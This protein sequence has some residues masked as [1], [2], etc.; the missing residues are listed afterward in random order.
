MPTVPRPWRRLDAASLAQK[1]ATLILFVLLT[2]AALLFTWHVL[3]AV[4]YRYPLDYGEGPLLDQAA[5]LAAGTNIYRADLTAPPYTISNYP[6]LYPLALALPTGLFGPSLAAGRAISGLC[7]VLTA[8]LLGLIV[9]GL[10]RDRCAAAVAGLT[11]LA[12]PY[13]LGWSKLAR[14]D[15]LA[16]ALSIGGLYLLVRWPGRWR[17]TILGGLLLVAAIYARQS[18]ALAAPLAAVGWLWAHDRRHAAGLAALVG[19]LSL[20]LFFGLNA[21]TGG[22]FAYNIITANVNDFVLA[23]LARWWRDLRGAAPVLLL[24]AGPFLVA[25]RRSVAW[26]LLAPYLIGASLSALTIG[27]V[28]SNMNYLLELCAA[29]SLMAGACVA[30]GR[31][32]PWLRATLLILL[33]LQVGLLMRASWRDPIAGLQWRMAQPRVALAELEQIIAAADGP[34][35]ADEYM[36]LLALQAKPL[37]IQPFEVTQL[38]KAGLWDQAP[39][40]SNI[41]ARAFPAIFIQHFRGYPVYQ[42][43]WTPEMLAAIMAHYEPTAFLAETIVYWPRAAG[44]AATTACPGGLW[45]LPTRSEMGLWQ[46]DRRLLFMGAGYEGDVPVYAVADG[47][48]LRPAGWYDAVAIQHDDPL[49]PGQKVWTYYGGMARGQGR[50]SLVAPRFTPGSTAVPVK[51]G[52]LLGYQGQYS[53]QFGTPF[54]VHLHFAVV[55]AA[56]DGTLPSEAVTA[57]LGWPPAPAAGE[58]E[59]LLAAA[60]YLG[61][62]EDLSPDRGTWRPL[63]CATGR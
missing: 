57:W 34:I 19:G 38:A 43:R 39:L 51:Q 63:R 50:G 30:W 11:L 25:G 24:L 16:L 21:L 35:L 32:C 41:R 45:R 47:L 59:E 33:A 55:P 54:W 27:K 1:S 12:F 58:G 17:G 13:V 26:P 56:A 29:L 5:R 18:Y 10:T 46:A 52:Q 49:R 37:Y 2:V 31:R 60:G 3:Q 42:E 36:G 48:L 15:L 61:I 44:D 7:A 8:L 62:T 40:L 6:P 28:G 14:V 53:A 9:H 20:G 4:G 22:G 23:N